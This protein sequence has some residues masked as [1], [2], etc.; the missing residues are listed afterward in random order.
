MSLARAE[1]DEFQF[2]NRLRLRYDAGTIVLHWLTAALVVALFGTAWIWNNVP[3]DWHWHPALEF[4][5]VSVGILFAAVILGR[6]AWRTLA[7][8]RLPVE[9]GVW[10]LASQTVHAMLYLLLAAQAAIG[11]VLRWLQGEA[12]SFFGLFAIPDPLAT[13]RSAAHVFEQLHNFVG[14]TIVYVALAHALA[15][16]FHRYVLKDQVLGR[17]L[18]VSR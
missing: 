6:L 7:G 11:F 12:F 17:M 18:P 14:W 13:S 16:L 8:R 4:V 10:G 1:A 15:A 2:G 3:R 5:H 9:G